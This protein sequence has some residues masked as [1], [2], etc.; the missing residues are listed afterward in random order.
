MGPKVRPMSVKPTMRP[1]IA[2]AW[3]GP[4]MVN[5]SAPNTKMPAVTPSRNLRRPHFSASGP[6][7]TVKMPKKTTPMI[8]IQRKSDRVIPRPGTNA[9]ICSAVMGVPAFSA[10]ACAPARVG[11]VP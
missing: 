2:A 11:L 9:A 10:A 4:N 7:T 6:E 1:T 8:S 3:P 5:Q